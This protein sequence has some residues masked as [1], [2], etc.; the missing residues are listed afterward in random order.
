MGGGA[1]LEAAGVLEAGIVATCLVL[2]GDF[3]PH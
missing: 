2:G 3:A 1:E